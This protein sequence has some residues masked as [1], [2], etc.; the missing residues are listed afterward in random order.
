[1]PVFP[2]SSHFE[3]FMAKAQRSIFNMCKFNA[4][5]VVDNHKLV[6]ARTKMYKDRL[7]ALGDTQVSDDEAPPTPTVPVL[8]EFIFPEDGYEDFF[9][10]SP[11]PSDAE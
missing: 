11:A 7:R 2:P 5:E 6:Y 8:P 9:V 4:Q 3:K 1:M 10:E